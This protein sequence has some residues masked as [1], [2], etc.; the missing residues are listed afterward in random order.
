MKRKRKKAKLIPRLGPAQNI[1]PA[2]AHES[3]KLYR[4]HRMKAALR[5]EEDGF[6]ALQPGAVGMIQASLCS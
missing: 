6:F 1:R 4:R 3:R 2:G 5:N